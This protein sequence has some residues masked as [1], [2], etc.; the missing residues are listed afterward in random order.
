MQ[1]IGHDSRRDGAVRIEE[2]LADV[3]IAHVLAVGERGDFL[4]DRLDPVTRGTGLLTPW[5]HAQKQD[6]SLRQSAAQFRDDRLDPLRDLV[7]CIIGKVVGADH[8]HRHFG[9]DPVELAI[10]DP[11]QDMLGA[12]ASNA[13]I[14]GVARPVVALPDSVVVPTL[15]DR[16]AQKEEI[17]VALF[18][19]RQEVFMH[20]HPGALARRRN[21]SGGTLRADRQARRRQR[22]D[23]DDTQFRQ[24]EDRTPNAHGGFS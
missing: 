3:E 13:E 15:R 2:G 12:V 10:L 24:Q 16:V 23:D 9:T 7:G 1:E 4:V 6:L 17:N 22:R 21:D 18:R 19:L 20:F 11:P 5:E 14:G 8:E